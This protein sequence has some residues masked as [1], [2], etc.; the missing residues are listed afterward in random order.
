MGGKKVD[1][2]AGS[3]TVD[4]NKNKIK[5]TL[6]IDKDEYKDIFTVSKL[7][8]TELTF[9]DIESAKQSFTRVKDK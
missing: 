3:Y 4:G 1:G 8:D 2:M 5:V 9:T 6:K 7:T